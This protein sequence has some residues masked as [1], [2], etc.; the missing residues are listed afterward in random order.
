MYRCEY[1]EKSAKKLLHPREASPTFQECV[2]LS[3]GNSAVDLNFFFSFPFY[4]ISRFNLC[5]VFNST[6]TRMRQRFRLTI[7][8]SSTFADEIFKDN[9]ISKLTLQRFSIQIQVLVIL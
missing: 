2:T 9:H 5:L 7:H 1:S 8:L 6:F 3:S 4:S